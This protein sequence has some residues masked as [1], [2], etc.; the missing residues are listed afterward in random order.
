MSEFQ[1]IE[2]ICKVSGKKFTVY[3]EDQ[4]FYA[5]KGVP[6]PTLCPQ[7]RARR[8]YAFINNE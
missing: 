4:E 2:K 1:P 8:K 6:L 3:P 5:K 7:E